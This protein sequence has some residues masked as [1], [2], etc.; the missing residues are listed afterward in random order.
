MTTPSLPRKGFRNS[1]SSVREPPAHAYKRSR[2]PT[3]A[4]QSMV[5]GTV[6][7][8]DAAALSPARGLPARAAMVAAHVYCTALEDRKPALL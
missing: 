6:V 4:Q 7:N 3:E 8:A 1:W 5:R 2:A